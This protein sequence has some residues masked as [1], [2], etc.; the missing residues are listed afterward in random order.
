VYP[1]W[2]ARLQ[3]RWPDLGLALAVDLEDKTVAN[4]SP[5]NRSI[6]VI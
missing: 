6:C 3:P 1:I 5:P 4:A 2:P